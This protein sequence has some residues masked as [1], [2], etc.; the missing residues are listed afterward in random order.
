MEITGQ[1]LSL[2]IQKSPL[3]VYLIAILLFGFIPFFSGLNILLI[4]LSRELATLK[5]DRTN[6]TQVTCELTSSS[7]LGKNVIAI[8]Q[9]YRAELQRNHYHERVILMTENGKIPL[10]R[11]YGGS[12]HLQKATQ[13]ND[14]I[15]NSVESSL[16]IQVDQRDW[17]GSLIF[18]LFG[19]IAMLI[20]SGISLLFMLHKSVTLCV[21]DKS[22][23]WVYLKKQNLL[24]RSEIRQE[25][26]TSIRGVQATFD[27]YLVFNSGERISLSL[28]IPLALVNNHFKTAK[29]INDFLDI[30]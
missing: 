5:C 23:G 13:I 10:T 11:A 29:P 24:L 26:L 27:T 1:K 2:K 9:L 15:N 19:G 25:R 6:R 4:S 8:R 14:F 18:F 17:F 12:S 22:S 28:L 20:G 3:S 7:F 30:Q 21:F 16:K